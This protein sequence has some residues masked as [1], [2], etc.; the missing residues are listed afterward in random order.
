MTDNPATRAADEVAALIEKHRAELKE[1]YT[2]S[3]DVYASLTGMLRGELIYRLTAL[4]IL[5]ER[6]AQLEQDYVELQERLYDLQDK[7][8]D[9]SAADRQE[10]HSELNAMHKRWLDALEADFRNRSAK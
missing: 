10:H 6:H 3:G 4:Y 5:Q 9:E 7:H 2:D 8:A 1:I